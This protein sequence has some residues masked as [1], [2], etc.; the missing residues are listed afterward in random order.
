MGSKNDGRS[1]TSWLKVCLI[2][3][4]GV[5]WRSRTANPRCGNAVR[6][7]GTEL[8]RTV[9][10]ALISFDTQLSRCYV[11]ISV[12]TPMVLFPIS[13]PF[14]AP[15]A[16]IT[17]AKPPHAELESGT[18]LLISCGEAV[19]LPRLRYPIPSTSKLGSR[20]KNSD[21]SADRGRQFVGF[22]GPRRPIAG[23]GSTG[24]GEDDWLGPRSVSPPPR[25]EPHEFGRGVEIWTTL[26]DVQQSLI[27]L[28][29]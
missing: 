17:L 28:L 1:W 15:N 14:S 20:N 8:M 12:S 21:S 25:P 23:R 6:L 2:L 26:Q 4:C 16:F 7:G 9:H 11:V 29:M 13:P 24:R 22:W 19:P 27:H 5:I 3:H 10:G 18:T